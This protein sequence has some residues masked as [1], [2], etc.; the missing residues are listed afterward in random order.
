MIDSKSNYSKGYGFVSF[1]DPKDFIR[2]M[3]EMQGKY[4]GSRPVKLQKSNWANRNVGQ[5]KLEK[6]SS[7]GVYVKRAK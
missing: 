7:S 3:R 5:G 6:L 4:I 1:K 2:A